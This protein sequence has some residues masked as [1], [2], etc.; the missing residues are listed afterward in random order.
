M[1][2]NTLPVVSI[3]FSNGKTYS[4][5]GTADAF[6]DPEFRERATMMNCAAFAKENSLHALKEE[7]MR[8]IDSEFGKD[9]S[10]PFLAAAKIL[11]ALDEQRL[12]KE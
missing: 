11:M 4:V 7:L 5:S 8:A 3:T 10:A 2:I 6:K 12:T 9:N 1:N